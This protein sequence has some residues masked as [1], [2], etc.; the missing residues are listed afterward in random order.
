MIKTQK[1]KSSAR[2]SS[3]IYPLNESY[4]DVIDCEEKAYFLGFLYADG[5]NHIKKGCVTLT[6]QEKD[7]EILIRLSKL[8]QP[9][10]PLQH[11]KSS[12]GFKTNQSS[13]RLV[14]ASKHISKKLAFLGCVGNKTMLLEFPG[15]NQ[16]SKE[17]QR[18][19]IRGYFDGDG[20]V[21]KHEASLVGTYN[22]CR[23]ISEISEEIIGG[24]FYLRHKGNYPTSEIIVN[25][26]KAR[27][28]LHWIYGDSTINLQRK[29][30]KYK[31]QLQY[32]YDLKKLRL[33]AV[34]DCNTVQICKNLCQYHY[35]Q[36]R[37]NN[38]S[39]RLKNEVKWIEK[40]PDT[41]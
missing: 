27:K 8:L 3:R 33:C 16:V 39:Y 7:K 22:F 30:T 31:L 4:F 12:S 29:Y 2:K 9:T 35:D 26:R 21:G 40:C 36:V 11:L 28:F 37:K 34:E 41:Q 13:Y 5:C 17:L 18:H 6:L 32:E 14:L 24:K 25:R 15:E 20:C 1:Q 19:F 10:K 23:K 38:M